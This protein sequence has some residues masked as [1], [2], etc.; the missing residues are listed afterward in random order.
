MEMRWTT[1]KRDSSSHSDGKGSDNNGRDK[2]GDEDEEEEEE[3][4][5]EDE[6]E[7]EEDEDDV[8]VWDKDEPFFYD[9]EIPGISNWDLLGEDFEREAAALGLYSSCMNYLPS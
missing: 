7:D 6:D 5:E 3:D 9:S 4:E 1:S 8:D 2:D